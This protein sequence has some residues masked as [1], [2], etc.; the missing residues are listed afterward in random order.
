VD[1]VQNHIKSV[2]WVT[3][4]QLRDKYLLLIISFKFQIINSL[5]MI[6]TEKLN[7]SMDMVYLKINIQL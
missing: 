7:M 1:S 5:S 2:N 3:R 6:F 4:V